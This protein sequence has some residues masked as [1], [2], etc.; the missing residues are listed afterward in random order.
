[1]YGKKKPSLPVK[2]FFLHASELQIC[3]PGTEELV[4]FTAELPED[5]KGVLK[6]LRNTPGEN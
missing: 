5:L 4:T 6:L 3:L 2:R 1:V